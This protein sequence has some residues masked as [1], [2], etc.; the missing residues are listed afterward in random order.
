MKK[1]VIVAGLLLALLLVAA[2]WGIGRLA[3]S[4]VDRGLEQVVAAAPYL[5]I[6]DREYA[7]GWFRSEQRVTF[8]FAAHGPEAAA[9]EPAPQRVTVHNEILHGPVL[10]LA[11]FG[12]ANV[13]TRV[14]WPADARALFVETF[15]SE[16]PLRV[17]TR[18]GFFGGRRTTLSIDGHELTRERGE[19]LS[20]KDA[21]LV[22]TYTANLDSIGVRG[23]W[24]GMEAVDAQ[25]GRQF[26]EDV[27]LDGES[28]RIDGDLYDGDV[29]LRAGRTGWESPAGKTQAADL[30]YAVEV[31]EDDGF[32]S[33]EFRL[34]SGAITTS[35]VNVNGGG[36]I[37]E[38]HADF[39]IRR[40]D[41]KLLSRLVTTMKGSYADPPGAAE[42]IRDQT[43]ALFTKDPELAVERVGFSTPDGDAYVKGVLRFR[44]VLPEDLALGGLGLIAKAEAK[45]DLDADAKLLRGLPAGESTVD[46][47]L[48]SGF[49]REAG[50]K[51]LSTLELAAGELKINGKVQGIPGLGSPPPVG[52][53]ELPPPQE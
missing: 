2:P 12:V 41:T 14:D 53:T 43:L 19:K 32:V 10:W 39:T 16:E 42:A 37:D 50:E 33:V 4:R 26:V 31:D 17:A 34:G 15:G 1:I 27:T 20:W 29:E 23:R 13:N 7:R 5:R 8:A 49:L 52:G 47:M 35:L 46:Q 11:G 6:V 48:A 3:E 45:L 40:L 30:F 51:L 38:V 24:S 28:D 9:S 18:I 36:K 22:V 21:R 44:G 25:G